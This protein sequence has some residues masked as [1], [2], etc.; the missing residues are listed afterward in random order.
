MILLNNSELSAMRGIQHAAIALYLAIRQAMDMSNGFVGLK[1]GQLVSWQGFTESLYVEPAAGRVESGSPHISTVRRLAAELERAGL[2]KNTSAQMTNQKLR[3]LIFKCLLATHDK[4]VQNKPD[5]EADRPQAQKTTTK[6]TASA[7]NP[8]EP[9][10]EADIHPSLVIYSID[11]SSSSERVSA[12]NTIL[13]DDDIQ[14]NSNPLPVDSVPLFY[15]PRTED[16]HERMKTMMRN[17]PHND[18]QAMLD[19]L[20]GRMRAGKVTS[21]MGYFKSM[22]EHYLKGDF[23]GELA[24]GEKRIREQRAKERAAQTERE[25]KPVCQRTKA[26]IDAESHNARAALFEARKILNRVGA[27]V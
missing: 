21:P 7:Q 10:R 24:Q 16:W 12:E 2:I 17:I 25:Q 22:I 5:R 9:D 26:E 14:S 4:S 1:D 8:S 3:Q 19:E 11:N 20:A 23:I 13:T 27:T 15:P 18:Q 6:T